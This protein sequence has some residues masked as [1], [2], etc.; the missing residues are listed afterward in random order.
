MQPTITEMPLYAQFKINTYL[1]VNTSKISQDISEVY[2]FTCDMSLQS[3]L[4]ETGTRVLQNSKTKPRVETPFFLPSSQYYSFFFRQSTY[5]IRIE[6]EMDDL[7]FFMNYILSRNTFFLVLSL[8]SIFNY[9]NFLCL[10]SFYFYSLLASKG[11]TAW[12]ILGNYF[13]HNAKLIEYI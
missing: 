4:R 11:L 1:Q 6:N 5:N 9:Y 2:Q 8:L 7:S 10:L 3:C 13:N 12:Q